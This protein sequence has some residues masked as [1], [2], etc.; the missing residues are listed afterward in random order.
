MST[1]KPATIKKQTSSGGVIFRNS[2][3]GIEVALIAVKN[4]TVWCLP[5]GAID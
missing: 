3:K 5:K 1:A 4:K 2:R